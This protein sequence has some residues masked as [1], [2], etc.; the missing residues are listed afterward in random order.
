MPAH[1]FQTPRAGSVN[2]LKDGELK[3]KELSFDCNELID[4]E[5]KSGRVRLKEPKFF[6]ELRL[7]DVRDPRFMVKLLTY[8]NSGSDKPRIEVEE[9][10]IA[11]FT[12]L[13]AGRD[14]N[15]KLLLVRVNFPAT[16]VKFDKFKPFSVDKESSY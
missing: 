15:N 6:K 8:V 3:L 5:A 4:K 11:P 14:K 13:R 9:R 12:I 7:K 10:F 1:D 2:V 16:I